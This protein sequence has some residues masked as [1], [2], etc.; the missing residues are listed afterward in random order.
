[1]MTSPGDTIDGH[2]LHLPRVAMSTM[3][4]SFGSERGVAFFGNCWNSEKVY[5]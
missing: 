1:M 3:M 5:V 2:C 4:P